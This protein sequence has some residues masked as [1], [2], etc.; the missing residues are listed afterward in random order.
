MKDWIDKHLI[1]EWRDW[2]RMASNSVAALLAAVPGFFIAFD[3]GILVAAYGVVMSMPAG[4]R[5]GAI[6]FISL[7]LFALYLVAR[8]WRQ[9]SEEKADD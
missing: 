4:T 8:L 1:D 9:E 3:P 2:W 5:V 7:S 6:A